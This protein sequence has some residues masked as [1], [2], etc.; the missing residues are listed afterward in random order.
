MSKVKVV[1]VRNPPP[2]PAPPPPVSMDDDYEGWWELMY[3]NPT[4]VPEASEVP[5]YIKEMLGNMAN[6]GMI[7]VKPKQK[8]L[9]LPKEKVCE[10]GA[11]G[12][13]QSSKDDTRVTVVPFPGQYL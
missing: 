3:P 2:P 4:V 9:P 7:E 1:E 12:S 8:A 5:E 13:G 10:P 6:A 11:E